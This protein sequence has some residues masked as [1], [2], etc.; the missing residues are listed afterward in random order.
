MLQFA[1]YISFIRLISHREIQPGLLIQNGFVVAEGIK[2]DLT[3][4]RTHTAFTNT[5]EAKV[6]SCQ[7]YDNVIYTATTITATLSKLS[8]GVFVF[9]ENVESQRLGLVSEKSINFVYVAVG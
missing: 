8:N 2:S 5:T 9:G 7:M 6:G 1:V 4:I 3:V